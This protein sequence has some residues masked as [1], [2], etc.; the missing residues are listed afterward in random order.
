MKEEIIRCG[1]DSSYF[2]KNYCII[3][4]PV[5]G[6]IPFDLYNYQ[7]RLLKSF[8]AKGRFQVVKA[9]QQGFDTIIAGYM[10]WASMFHAQRVGLVLSQKST[11]ARSIQEKIRN[12]YRRLPSWLQITKVQKDN[13]SNIVFM[14]GSSIFADNTNPIPHYND[15]IDFLY[16]QEACDIKNMKQIWECFLPTIVCTNSKVV[17]AS[18]PS[19]GPSWFKNK[20][21]ENKKDKYF[22][23]I[24]LDWRA[25][26][27]W[28]LSWFRNMSKILSEKQVKE[29][30]LANFT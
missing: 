11:M 1:S 22:E 30:L 7:E 29:A 19:E 26:P 5:R 28:N 13:K 8:S 15:N 17:I 23:E 6:A 3:D 18:T 21:E 20:I 27:E 4:H 24:K 2:M 12:M 16:I 14:N 10:L 25:H 9:R